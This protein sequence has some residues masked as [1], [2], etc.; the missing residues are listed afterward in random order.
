M[1]DVSARDPSDDQMSKSEVALSATSR[2]PS[3][4]CDLRALAMMTVTGMGGAAF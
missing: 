3:P 2:P 1:E 4:Q